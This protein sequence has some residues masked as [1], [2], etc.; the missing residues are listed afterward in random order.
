MEM[1]I[2]GPCAIRRSGAPDRAAG[3]LRRAIGAPDSSAGVSFA[4]GRE[5]AP[6]WAPW[7]GY[8]ENALASASTRIQGLDQLSIAFTIYPETMK[9]EFVPACNEPLADACSEAAK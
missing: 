3:L 4:I 2:G 7:A 9:G 5:V 8:M 1:F 6:H